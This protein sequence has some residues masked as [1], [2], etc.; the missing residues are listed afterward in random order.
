MDGASRP[1]DA[2]QAQGQCLLRRVAARSFAILGDGPLGAAPER[3]APAELGLL[4]AK[5]P[6]MSRHSLALPSVLHT[7]RSL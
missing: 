2:V 3:G 5:V 7:G 6:A 4:A 1:Q